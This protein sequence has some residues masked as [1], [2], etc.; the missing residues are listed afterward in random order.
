MKSR[1]RA[2][3]AE[4]RSGARGGGPRLRPARVPR[5]LDRVC[6]R[7]R[8][9]DSP[10]AHRDLKIGA[11]T[12]RF[13]SRLE[14]NWSVG[15]PFLVSGRNSLHSPLAHLATRPERHRERVCRPDPSASLTPIN[16]CYGTQPTSS[17]VPSQ[18]LSLLS[19]HRSL[20]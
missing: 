8:V 14:P 4:A 9:I 13:G 12:Y 2:P 18:S 5:V 17:M 10:D 1:A 7:G 3:Y 15:A 6:E 19:P 20:A 16:E 11:W